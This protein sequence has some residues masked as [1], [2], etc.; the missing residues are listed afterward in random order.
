MTLPHTG[1]GEW[2]AS[3]AS[4][5][6]T[7]N[8]ALRM[9][10]AAATRFVIEDRD[11]A[12]PPG[13]CSDGGCYLVAASPTGAW[14]GQAGKLAVAIGTNASN[15]WLFVTV[16]AEGNQIYV[17]D[18]DLTIEHNGTSWATISSSA[19][20]Y[21]I[22]FFFTSAPSSSEVLLLHIATEAFTFPA[23]FASPSSKG[24]VGSNPAGSFVLDVQRQ[25][26]ATGSFSSIGTITISTGG[27]FTFA[28]VSGTSKSVA[29]N[30]V[31]KIVGPSSADASIANAA[32][33][34]VG[35][36]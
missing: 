26:N 10:D 34:L 25:V 32:I 12:A 14:S 22:G 18:E 15:G 19:S 5:W 2:A 33:T 16:A 27:A 6:E 29:V 36:I 4:P 3:Q 7:V 1:A 13:S 35:D 20:Q 30:D 31:I 21:R 23:N 8:A 28:T 9:L 17:R 24:A 11:L